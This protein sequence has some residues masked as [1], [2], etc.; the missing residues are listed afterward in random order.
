M[1][2]V[3]EKKKR[4]ASVGPDWGQVVEDPRT[5]AL[6]LIARDEHY[7]DDLWVRYWANG[8]EAKRLDFEAFLYRITEP[9]DF[10]LQILAWALEE[11]AP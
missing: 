8:G 1:A 9:N 10:D 7:L 6:E 3:G 2:A 5:T 11:V 4:R